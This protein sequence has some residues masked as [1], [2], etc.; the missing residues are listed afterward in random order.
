M[1]KI[2]V[3]RFFFFCRVYYTIIEKT[4]VHN[5]KTLF[6]IQKA[7]NTTCIRNK[8]TRNIHKSDW[9]ETDDPNQLAH[10]EYCSCL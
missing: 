3:K 5:V 10:P 7:F 2:V 9:V 6:R 8:E 1:G 4:Q